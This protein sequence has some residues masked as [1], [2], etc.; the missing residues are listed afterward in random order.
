M[1]GDDEIPVTM[2]ACSTSTSVA[3]VTRIAA[4][5]AGSMTYRTFPLAP[6]MHVETA[7]DVQ[8]LSRDEAGLI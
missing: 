3:I 5:A 1:L 4:S 7:I 6:S 2:I 8:R